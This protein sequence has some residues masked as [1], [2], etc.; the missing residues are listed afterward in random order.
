MHDVQGRR[1]S[2]TRWNCGGLFLLGVSRA[3]GSVDKQ[4]RIALAH[5]WARVT[6]IGLALEGNWNEANEGIVRPLLVPCQGVL[7]LDQVGPPRRCA[8]SRHQPLL[9]IQDRVWVREST[10]C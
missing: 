4:T 5:R 7:E 8:Q 1:L 6:V 9:S 10:P 2:K 3:T